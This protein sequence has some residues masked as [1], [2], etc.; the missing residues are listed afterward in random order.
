MTVLK[1]EGMTCGHC[2]SRVKQAVGRAAPEAGVDVDLAA[3]EVRI[4]GAEI[5]DNAV[6][7][8]IREAG[9]QPA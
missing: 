9:Y 6:K 4:S 8:A 3:G 1:V 7:A 5:D 2:A